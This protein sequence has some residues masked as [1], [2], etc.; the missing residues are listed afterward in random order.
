MVSVSTIDNSRELTAPGVR[1]M[2][3]DE[4]TDEVIRE[5]RRIKENLAK[6]LDF[7]V[8]R[9]LDDA[10]RRQEEGGRKILPPPH[11]EGA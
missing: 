11:R 10:R 6:S 4:T 7:D 5:V 2:A 1:C 3:K 8:D 9:I